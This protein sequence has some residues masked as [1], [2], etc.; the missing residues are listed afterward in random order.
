MP[1]PSTRLACS[2][3]FA[4]VLGAAACSGDNLTAPGTG[5]LEVT[6]TTAGAE[7]DPDG[8]MVQI[9]AEAAQPLGLTETMRKTEIAPGDHAVQ[10]S[11]IAPNCAVAGNNPRTV[12]VAAGQTATVTFEI[13]CG[14]TSGGLQVTAATSGPSPDAD[15]YTLTVDGAEQGTLPPS[16][17]ATLAA[18]IPGAH[19][20]GLS[21]VAGNC[22]VEGDNPRAVTVVAGESG[23]LAFVVTCVAPPANAGTLRVT[24]ATTGADPDPNGYSFTVDGGASQ[25]IGVNG[26]ASLA[27]VAGGAHSVQ[28]G[29]L[30]ENC[31]V[32]GANP[33]SVTVSSGATAEASFAVTCTVPSPTTSDIVFV[34]DRTGNNDVFTMKRDGSG[35]TNLTH[36]D[37]DDLGGRWSPDGAKIAFEGSGDI[38]VMNA[39]GSGQT[40]LTQLAGGAQPA[41]SPDGRRIAFKSARNGNFQIFVMNADGSGQT[42]LTNNQNGN[43][44]PEWSPDGRRIA[45]GQAPRIWV[46]NSDGSA[47]SPMTSPVQNEV[48]FGAQW[49]PDGSKIAFIRRAVDQLEDQVMNLWVMNADGSGSKALTNYP[50]G[51]GPDVNINGY[52]WSPDSRKLT[53]AVRTDIHVIGADGTGEVNLTNGS[54]LGAVQPCWSPDGSQILF[55]A[56]AGN[57]PDV[58][59]MNADGSHPTNL[60]NNAAWDGQGAWRP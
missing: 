49:S 1:R 42:S 34:S 48:D 54:P 47:Q 53:F 43:D 6:A 40:N 22:T 44:D 56:V 52:S 24:T 15:G 38:R 20:I 13:T 27:N 51:P 17:A 10:L 30:A 19:E 46:M 58:F 26:S 2:L 23:T 8:Y 3:F 41:W 35:Q 5:T 18:L 36:A 32:Q 37:G 28:L 55:Y 59:V 12:S 39:D 57:A 25:P 7:S 33:R 50:L 21:G 60:T 16:G 4:L 11:G 14:A 9:D 45:F 31:T 29:G